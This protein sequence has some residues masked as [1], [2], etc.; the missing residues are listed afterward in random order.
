MFISPVSIVHTSY[1][2]ISRIASHQTFWAFRRILLTT[3]SLS[4]NASTIV[5]WSLAYPPVSKAG[6]RMLHD[7]KGIGGNNGEFVEKGGEK[8]ACKTNEDVYTSTRVS[9]FPEMNVKPNMI[10]AKWEALMNRCG[11]RIDRTAQKE[12]QNAQKRKRSTVLAMF[13]VAGSTFCGLLYFCVYYGWMKRD[14]DNAYTGILAPY[15]RIK[16]ACRSWRNFV[17]EPSRDK[18]LPDP[19]KPPYWQPK[20]TVVIELKNVLVAPEWSYKMGNRVKKRPAVDYLLDVIGYPNFEVVIYTSETALNANPI[21][22]ALDSKQK[23]MYKL[24]RDC[25]KYMNGV[26]VKDLSKLNRDLSKV[27]YIDFD[28]ESFRCNPENVLRLPKWDGTLDDTALVDLAELLKTIHL[29][30]VDDVR[31]TLQYYSQFDDPLKEFRERATR[32]AELEKKM[33]RMESEKEAFVAPV[34][35]YQGRLFG[36]RRHE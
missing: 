6:L 25:C 7:V 19:L 9:A 22:E 18:L 13:F 20:Y 21:V 12:D 28:P 5:A 36:F 34:K 26:Y 2:C 4:G 10:V 32:V 17:V 29:S 15:Y 8:K 30:D 24:Y 11:L 33:H 14:E 27:I 1:R 16:G 23:I 31:P 35:K 3:K